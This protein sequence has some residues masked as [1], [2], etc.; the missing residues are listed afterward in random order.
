MAGLFQPGGFAG[1]PMPGQMMNPAMNFGTM[2]AGFAQGNPLG[3]FQTLGRQQQMANA[4]AMNAQLMQMRMAQF[5]R[6]Q[7]REQRMI[8]A[9]T[10]MVNPLLSGVAP[11]VMQEQTKALTTLAQGAPE[12]VLQAGL[13]R[14][15]LGGADRYKTVGKQL[16][17]VQTGQWISPP[18]GITEPADFSDV[19]NM[20]KE[21]T[22]ES[23]PWTQTRDAFERIRASRPSGAGDIN[24]LTSFMKMIDPGSVVREGEFATAANAGGIPERIRNTYNS[25]LRGDRLSDVQRAEFKNQAGALLD[26]ARR[27]Q[28]QREGDY[29]GIATRFG[30]RPEDIVRDLLGDYREGVPSFGVPEAEA[31]RVEVSPENDDYMKLYGNP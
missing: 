15:G 3:G 21:F 22:K 30:A 19:T 5:R 29:S 24:L 17:D 4:A 23:T 1:P 25:L 14:M 6:E 2:L 31:P 27:R 13:A 10:T 8:D 11:N 20:R 16:Y 12:L 28:L 26:V 7:E 9:A 18:G